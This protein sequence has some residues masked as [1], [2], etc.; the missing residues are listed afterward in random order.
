MGGQQKRAMAFDRSFVALA[1]IL[2]CCY[3]QTTQTDTSSSSDW[4]PGLWAFTGV[5]AGVVVGFAAF[6]ALHWHCCRECCI[7]KKEEAA[8]I[9]EKQMEN[10]HHEVEDD[11]TKE[12]GIHVDNTTNHELS[13]DDAFTKRESV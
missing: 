4:K 13:G 12:V 8:L 5:F 11:E 1:F 6:L 9:V 10:P 2:G 3:G 7:E